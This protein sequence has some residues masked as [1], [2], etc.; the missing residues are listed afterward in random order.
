[1]SSLGISADF[2]R[3]EDV[4]R[5]RNQV[6]HHYTTANPQTINEAITK[7]F[8]LICTFLRKELT[9]DPKKRIGAELWSSFVKI[10]EVYQTEK[11][12]CRDSHTNFKSESPALDS[13][14]DML[15]CSACD[16]DLVQIKQ[17]RSQ[18]R[19]CDK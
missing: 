3:L 1:M 19:A 9:T 12:A 5:I 16:S 15:V 2:K 4:T 18:C 14:I 17:D 7:S 11:D 6:E 10:Q 13:Q 8:A